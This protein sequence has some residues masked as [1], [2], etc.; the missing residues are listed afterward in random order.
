[1][2]LVRLSKEMRLDPNAERGLKEEFPQAAFRTS[3]LRKSSPSED[4]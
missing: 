1:M 3:Q 2:E 4:A